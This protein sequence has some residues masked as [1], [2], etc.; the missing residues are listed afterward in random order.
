VQRAKEATEKVI[1]ATRQLKA[2]LMRHLFTYGPVPVDQ[3]DRV[4]LKE[5][6]VGLVPEHWQV[7]SIAGISEVKTSTASVDN[8]PGRSE[9]ASGVPVFFLKV[10][11]MNLPG[12][13]RVFQ[14]AANIVYINQAH[15]K[16]LNAVP[17]GSTVLPKR[18]AAIATNKKRLTKCKCLL[19]PNLMAIVPGNQITSGF[20]FAWMERFD[21]RTITDTTT[22]PQLNKKDIEPLKVTLPPLD[23]Q[24]KSEL[25]L[26]A[27]E[28]SLRTCES[29]ESALENL[30]GSLLH[31]LMT[32]KLR[33][34]D[35]D[36][37]DHFHDGTAAG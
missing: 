25:F 30:F 12:N 19:D 17:A 16:R 10:S 14:N 7:V 3:A 20:L 34:K 27:V 24:R 29:R 9:A 5:T 36:P 21:L 13:E 37:T 11:D 15:E 6:E 22:L 26:Q 33:V 35:L 2:S 18:G 23:E 4:R 1:A 32:G 8:I 28:Q 31:H